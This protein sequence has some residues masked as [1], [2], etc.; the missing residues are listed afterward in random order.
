MQHCSKSP[1]TLPI[2]VQ[3]FT[4]AFDS[5]QCWRCTF[6]CCVNI[7]S[8]LLFKFLQFF[9]PS[10]FKEVQS[11]KNLRNKRTTFQQPIIF[12]ANVSENDLNV[13]KLRKHWN[14]FLSLTGRL[15]SSL[16]KLEFS[17]L[18][19]ISLLS[20]MLNK[21]SFFMIW[22]RVDLIL[23]IVKQTS[24]TSLNEK[25]MSGEKKVK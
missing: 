18:V 23:M 8:S 19:S 20:K 15:D 13:Q 6:P 16:F 4:S 25:V 11:L 1:E 14:T 2:Q 24:Q 7:L 5:M 17:F 12:I 10:N 21:T 3:H 22:K 9:W